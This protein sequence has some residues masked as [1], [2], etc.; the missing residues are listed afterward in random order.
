MEDLV[1]AWRW[2]LWSPNDKQ[3]H[4][5]VLDFMPCFA[6]VMPLKEGRN[7]CVLLH[8][9]GVSFG[10]RQPPKV[11]RIRNEVN[12]QGV[13]CGDINAD[14]S[15]ENMAAI[16]LPYVYLTRHCSD[17]LENLISTGFQNMHSGTKLTANDA[18]DAKLPTTSMS[19]RPESNGRRP[20]PGF[21][22]SSN[23]VT[24]LLSL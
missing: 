24:T 1:A 16:W 10:G 11:R 14:M 13:R 23:F 3:W 21:G 4:E 9:P 22:T 8:Y 2:G 15:I 20:E 19:L 12:Q 7:V 6:I 17:I 18:T 5:R